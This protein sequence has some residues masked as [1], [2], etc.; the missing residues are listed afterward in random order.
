MQGEN[1]NGE[2]RRVSFFL[3]LSLLRFI[4]SLIITKMKAVHIRVSGLVQGVGYRYFVL[5]VARGLGIVGCVRNMYN[6][7]VEIIGEGERG[8]LNQLVEEAKIGPISSDVRGVNIEW[9]EPTGEY[10]IFDIQF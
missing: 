5:R 10:S 9:Q 2:Q 4:S 6:G 8:V 1:S 7:T 3:T